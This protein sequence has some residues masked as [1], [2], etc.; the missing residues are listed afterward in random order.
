MRISDWS[1]DVCSSDL[2]LGM[3]TMFV[4][5]HAGVL[6]AYGMGLADLRILREAA[7]EAEL[8]DEA[9]IEA[10]EV[11]VRIEED[12]RAEM[13]S[14]GVPLERIECVRR[15]HLRYAG[16]DKALIVA[17]ANRAAMRAAFEEMHRQRSRFLMEA[18]GLVVGAVS[19]QV[20]AHA[21]A[22]AA[23]GDA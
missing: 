8:D 5:P 18:K 10:D 3:R 4:H 12:G 15:A 22:G 20:V 1:S 17:F 11:I 6:S 14:Q 2:A 16:T 21:A 19:V 13:E 7:V 9:V 23:P